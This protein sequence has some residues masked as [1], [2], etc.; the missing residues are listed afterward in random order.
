[1]DREHQAVAEAHV[2]AA[3]LA[4]AEEAAIDEVAAAE[5]LRLRP[6]DEDPALVGHPAD[7]P[8]FGHLPSES[9]G[10]QVFAGMAGLAGEKQAV[11]EGGDL[12]VEVEELA[13]AP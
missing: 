5:A 4:L 13:P 10:F 12:A 7:H 3:A 1:P 9:P 2:N 8:A 6:F 11:E